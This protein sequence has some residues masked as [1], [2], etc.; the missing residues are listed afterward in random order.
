MLQ[1]GV[2]AVNITCVMDKE[3][4]IKKYAL[5][6]VVFLGILVISL[7]GARLIIMTRTAISLSEPI[8]LV[9]TGLSI[10]LPAS[11]G[12]ES[13]KGWVYNRYSFVLLSTM[14]GQPGEFVPQIE[15]KYH[16]VREKQGPEQWLEQLAEIYEAKILEQ[17]RIEKG[18]VVLHWGHF[19]QADNPI[20]N[21]SAIAVL[22]N[23]RLLTIKVKGIEGG[24]FAVDKIFE[25]VAGSVNFEDTGFL[26]AGERLIG[27][28]KTEGIDRFIE[29]TFSESYYVIKDG[30]FKPV[31]FTMDK[32]NFDAS[33]NTIKGSGYYYDRSRV[34]REE[35]MVFTCDRFFENYYM[36]S[37]SASFGSSRSIE[38]EIEKDGFMKVN[39]FGSAEKEYYYVMS[40]A[41][42]DFFIDIIL[43][44]MAL[45]DVDRIIVDM[46]GS[47]GGVLPVYIEKKGQEDGNSKKFE[48]EYLSRPGFVQEIYLDSDLRLY[49]AVSSSPVKI[50]ERT[51]KQALVKEFSER[52]DYILHSDQNFL[53]NE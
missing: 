52:G 29:D 6:K 21:Y 11:R 48:L 32:V 38:V 36:K 23:E 39:S 44:K 47:D 24:S 4:K 1:M 14:T 26:S 37:E 46:V 43:K 40:A 22:P 3:T 49:K 25:K 42:P 17:G 19:S 53:E 7:L 13:T 10:S 2:K 5:D 30:N 28:I 50:F 9:N 41:M 51:T 27:E 20:H 16:L 18:S 12:W 35:T 8:G 31:G 15:I 45:S 33:A 34:N